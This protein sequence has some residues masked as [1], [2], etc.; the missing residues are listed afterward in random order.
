MIGSAVSTQAGGTRPVRHGIGREPLCQENWKYDI[1]PL[2]PP[3]GTLSCLAFMVRVIVSMKQIPREKEMGNGGA[4]TLRK[5]KEQRKSDDVG[6]VSISAA[7]GRVDRR[8]SVLRA[9]VRQVDALNLS[10]CR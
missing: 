7:C 9:I 10:R 3:V 4:A 1:L 6:G 5:K 2:T 8:T